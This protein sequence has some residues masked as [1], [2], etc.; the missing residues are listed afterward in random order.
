MP[1]DPQE[2]EDCDCLTGDFYYLNFERKS[3]GIDK[4]Y[5]EADIIRCK[6]CRRYWLSYLM[7]YEYLTSAGRWFCGIVTPDVAASA[8]AESAIKILENLEWYY[9]G[10]S[11]FG[12]KVTRT[13]SGQLRYWLM[14][15]PRPSPGD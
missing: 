15:F 7:E 13:S 9:R 12:G 14:P 1:P 8:T 10:G 3:L 2:P 6:R 11:A 4:D 5:G